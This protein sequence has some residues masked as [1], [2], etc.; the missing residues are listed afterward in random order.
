MGEVLANFFVVPPMVVLSVFLPAPPLV[1]YD[2]IFVCVCGRG[3]SWGEW[4]GRDS[5]AVLEL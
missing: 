1:S 4:S 2:R 5:Q 3:R